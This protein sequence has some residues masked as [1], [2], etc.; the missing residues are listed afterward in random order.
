MTVHEAASAPLLVFSTRQ[1]LAVCL[2]K[3]T[4][5]PLFS[6]IINA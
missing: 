2:D 3:T 1:I 5:V 4:V 6:P